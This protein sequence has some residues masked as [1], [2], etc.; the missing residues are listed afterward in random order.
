MLTSL[1]WISRSNKATDYPLMPAFISVVLIVV[2]ILRNK[3]RTEDVFLKK[4]LKEIVIWLLI[5]NALFLAVL[6]PWILR[7]KIV[8]DRFSFANLSYT[9]VYYYNLP[10]LIA[11]QKYFL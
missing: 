2:F 11:V 8:Y 5:F 7:N 9:N 4:N 6:A 10:P 3:I 1:F